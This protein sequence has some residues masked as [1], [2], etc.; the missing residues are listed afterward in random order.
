MQPHHQK[1]SHLS[2]PH[3]MPLTTKVPWFRHE[4]SQVNRPSLHLFFL[5]GVGEGVEKTHALPAL[6]HVDHRPIASA[7]VDPCKASAI[8]QSTQRDHSGCDAI[9]RRRRSHLRVIKFLSPIF[10]LIDHDVEGALDDLNV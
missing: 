5:A 6:L 1:T 2:I 3:R 9:I 10:V 4:T 7:I 8:F